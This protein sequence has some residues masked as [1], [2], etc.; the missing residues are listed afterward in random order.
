MSANSTYRFLAVFHKFVDEKPIFGP[1]Y[2]AKTP[3]TFS[4]TTS[5]V[6]N[7]FYKA[8]SGYIAEGN[9]DPLRAG[10]HFRPHE[11]LKTPTEGVSGLCAPRTRWNSAALRKLRVR[12][13][14]FWSKSILFLPCLCSS[15]EGSPSRMLKN[16]TLSVRA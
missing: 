16:L 7:T 3:Q 2:P 8:R 15:D 6:V 5:N 10:V 13:V 1:P 9:R 12:G 14:H 11:M 4:S